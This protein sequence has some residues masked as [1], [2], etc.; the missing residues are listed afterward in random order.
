[1]LISAAQFSLAVSVCSD[2]L[3]QEESFVAVGGILMGLCNTVCLL[4][5]TYLHYGSKQVIK[6]L[7][8]LEKLPTNFVS[9]YTA[10]IE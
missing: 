7:S 4:N 6:E 2:S 5:H 8:A 10:V 1:M 3:K 9:I